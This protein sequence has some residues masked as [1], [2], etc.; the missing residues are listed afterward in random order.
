[1]SVDSVWMFTYLLVFVRASAM[2]LTSPLFSGSVP[3]RV[4]VLF[5]MMFAIC[6]TPIAREHVTAVP[7]EMYGLLAAV[8]HEAVI[9]LIIGMCLQILLLAAQMAGSLMDMQLGFQMMQ[10]F[11]PQLGGQTSVLGQFKF[12]LFLVLLLIMN[13]HHMMLNAFV[14]SYS[15][16][17]NFSSE[18][19]AGLK[20]GLVAFLGSICVLALQIAAPVT[21]VSF[22]VDAAAGVVNKAIPQMPVSMVTMGA[23]T[24]MGIA[25][26][27]IGLPLM[28][29]AVQSGVD[30]TGAKIAD[31]LQIVS[32]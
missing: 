27:S 9:G 20:D 1:M 18:N 23:K 19:L 28:L 30:H 15:I 8:V 10:M 12:L 11:N 5:C 24:S 25:A 21:A 22:I 2:F 14:E 26:I 32:R 17:P 31:L 4:R 29:V 3:A 7:T 13:G 6:I 16:N